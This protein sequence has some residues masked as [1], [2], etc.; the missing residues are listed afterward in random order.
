[1]VKSD[2]AQFSKVMLSGMVVEELSVTNAPNILTPVNHKEQL[3]H[4]NQRNVLE[5]LNLRCGCGTVLCH[6]SAASVFVLSTAAV[7][8][9]LTRISD[10]EELKERRKHSQDNDQS[11]LT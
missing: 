11:I 3:L 6:R 4:A 5:K 8:A 1:M 7:K 10:S 9:V 2:S